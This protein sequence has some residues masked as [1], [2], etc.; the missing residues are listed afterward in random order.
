M[1]LADVLPVPPAALA[2]DPGLVAAVCDITDRVGLERVVESQAIRRI[3][4]SAALLSTAI[5][6][7]PVRGVLVN[8]VGTANVHALDARKPRSR[9]YNV[10]T[11]DWHTLAQFCDAVPSVYPSLAVDPKIIPTGGFAGF[12]HCRPAPSDTRA[13]ASE[14]GFRTIHS[15][16]DTI[17]FYAAKYL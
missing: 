1:V 16:G 9:V 8:T 5:R 7:N 6:Q 10:A 17:Q 2:A 11:G 13:A 15:L 3:V 4:H 14:L 12:P